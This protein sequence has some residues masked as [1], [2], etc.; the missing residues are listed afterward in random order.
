[1]EYSLVINGRLPGMNDFI[2]AERTNRYKGAE[3]KKQHQKTVEWHIKQQLRNVH[4]SRK[5]R[6]FYMFYEQ[7]RKRDLDNICGFAHKVVQDALVQCRV[8][9]NDGWSEIGGFNDVFAVDAEHPR[10]EILIIEEE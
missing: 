4:I 1:M 2:K 9:K 8:L 5:V 3:F 6:L 7:N 10:I